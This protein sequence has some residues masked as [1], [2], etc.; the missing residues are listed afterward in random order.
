MSN[1]MTDLETLKWLLQKAG[2]GYITG[3]PTKAWTRVTDIP[4]VA[5]VLDAYRCH[6][7]AE[8]DKDGAILSIRHTKS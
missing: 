4:N 7:E 8:F 5:T 2:V 3:P 1:E 6:F